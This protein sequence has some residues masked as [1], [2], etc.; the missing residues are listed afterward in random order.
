MDHHLESYKETEKQASK[1]ISNTKSDKK[2]VT[3]TIKF[4][5]FNFKKSLSV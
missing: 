2:F 5:N 3:E 1:L 4:S